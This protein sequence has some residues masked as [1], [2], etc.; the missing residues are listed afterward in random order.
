MYIKNL[1]D[2]ARIVGIESHRLFQQGRDKKDE[3][4]KAEKSMVEE[5]IQL[6]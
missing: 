3:K 2:S 6:D 4:N 1:L 5:E